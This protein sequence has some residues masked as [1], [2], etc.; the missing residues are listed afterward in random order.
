[1][2]CGAILA[3]DYILQFILGRMLPFLVSQYHISLVQAALLFS[4]IPFIV[5]TLIN[6]SAYFLAGFFTARKGGTAIIACLWASLC[7]FVIYFLGLGINL[8]LLM[9]RDGGRI[10]PFYFTSIGIGFVT[11]LTLHGLGIGI[12]ALGG[13]LG[14]NSARKQALLAQHRY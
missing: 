8:F 4:T 13:L 14:K 1:L 5:L 2:I 11:A 3:G 10:P 9:A 7:Y 12:G 6:W